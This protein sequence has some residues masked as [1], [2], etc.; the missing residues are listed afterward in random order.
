MLSYQSSGQ[1]VD[2][3]RWVSH[4]Q[5]VLLRLENVI[6]LV[7]DAETAQRGYLLTGEGV[8]LASLRTAQRKTPPELRTLDSL[9]A[10]NPTQ[11]RRLDTLRALVGRHYARLDSN[12]AGSRRQ[13]P[14]VASLMQA[15]AQ[16]DQLR[17]LAS[18]LQAAE[19]ALLTRREAQAVRFGRVLPLFILGLTALSL[20]IVGCTNWRL[21]HSRRAARQARRRIVDQQVTLQAFLDA[22]PDGINVFEWEPAGGQAGGDFRLRLLNPAAE[23]TVGITAHDAGRWMSELFPSVLASGRLASYQHV[24]TTGE[25]LE[26][27]FFFEPHQRWLRVTA[28][29]AHRFL[30]VAFADVTA[31]KQQEQ[32]VL[33]YQQRKYEAVFNQTTQLVALLDGE[34]R[35]LDA[36]QTALDFA[37]LA[38]QDTGRALRR[39]AGLPPIWTLPGVV[40]RLRQAIRQATRGHT[41]RYDTLLR[42]TNGQEVHLDMSVKPVQGENG[43]TLFLLAEGNNIT[44]RK[45]AESDLQASYKQ[46]AATTADLHALSQTLEL[47]VQQR[48][49]LLEESR[50]RFAQ[51]LEA[52]PN[53]AWTSRPDGVITYYNRQWAEYTGVSAEALLQGGWQ[54]YIHPDD[55]APTEAAWWQAIQT[56]EPLA[57]LRNRWK[58][59]ATGDYRWHLVRAVP[60]HD[61]DGAIVLWVGSNTDI[62][63]QQ[64]QQQHLERVNQDLDN[65]IYTASHDLKTPISNIEGLLTMLR[66]ELQQAPAPASASLVLDMMQQSVNRFRRTIGHM[67]D[68]VKL[69][70]YY[71]LPIVSID[72]AALIEE[73]SDDLRPQLAATNGQLEIDIAGKPTVNFAQKNLR[74]VVFNLLSNALK[75]RHLG[76]VPLV[77]V[78]CYEAGAYAVLQVQD[79]GLGL[80][81]TPARQRKLFGLFQR[82]HDHVEGSGVGLYMVKKIM[83]NAGGRIE[84]ES[85][86]DVGTTFSLY[87]PQ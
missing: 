26:L 38:A 41:V 61:H 69:E 39:Y 73:V 12:A 66:K 27:E 55:L 32:R 7:K 79:N 82:L 83:E 70:K 15:K 54:D 48:T 43:E 31:R 34:G 45:R 56:G 28:A 62:H 58:E 37:G 53:M 2:S 68:I 87:F 4:T 64:L 63:A 52:I 16:L 20:L 71:E 25:P 50:A 57:E 85:Q 84:V 8:F 81:L 72:L 76:R 51:L 18:R 21:H 22:S 1:L 59:A 75:Y 42:Q 44:E 47:R 23:K 86:L 49:Q 11:Q 74:S 35:F 9:T 36:N 46:L 78:R 6:S 33:Y 14:A 3:Q 30:F 10:D 13:A 77:R 80:H 19:Q 17:G 60:L 40:P 65:F 67:T 29:R 24:M 5:V